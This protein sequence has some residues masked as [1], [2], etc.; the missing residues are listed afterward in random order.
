MVWWLVRRRQTETL[1]IS[2][3]LHPRI[4]DLVYHMHFFQ[5]LAPPA[6]C[7]WTIRSFSNRLQHINNKK[8]KTFSTLGTTSWIMTYESQAIREQRPAPLVLRRLCISNSAAWRCRIYFPRPRPRHEE[9][10]K[11]R[12]WGNLFGCFFS[13]MGGS[14]K[15]GSQIATNVLFVVLSGDGFTPRTNPI[16]PYM[17]TQKQTQAHVCWSHVISQQGYV[18]R[19]LLARTWLW[20]S[21]SVFTTAGAP[22][23]F[24]RRLWNSCG[25]WFCLDVRCSAR[26]MVILQTISSFIGRVVVTASML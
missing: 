5:S 25:R 8:K 19:D 17:N 21:A 20:T 2:P 13:W 7:F 6:R 14:R 9:N 4:I 3:P 22:S 15:N 18:H 1:W 12:R 16:W 11:T 23:W 26:D 24:R 10:R